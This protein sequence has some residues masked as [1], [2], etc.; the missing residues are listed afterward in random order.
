MPL[1]T[2]FVCKLS[3]LV[4]ALDSLTSRRA[5]YLLAAILAATVSLAA[6][7][8]T[9]AQLTLD[10]V[11]GSGGT[12]G[13]LIERKTGTTGAFAQIANTGA[14]VTT[15]ADTT[16]TAATTFCYRVRSANSGGT[17]GYSNEACGA[18][19]DSGTT[20]TIGKSGTGSGTVTSTPQGINCGTD[21]TE[22]FPAG[23]V[24]LMAAPAPGSIFGGW[25]GGGCTGTDAC[26][27]AGNVA[28]QVTATFAPTS[29]APTVTITSPASGST[30]S[31]SVTVVVAATAGSGTIAR[32]ELWIDGAL[33]ATATDAPYR[34]TGDS[35]GFSDGPHSLVARAYDTAGSVGTSAAVVLTNKNGRQP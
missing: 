13:F 18:A 1:V 9:G 20:L 32:V 24:T 28:L 7:A 21:C 25:S 4:R 22:S 17:S 33:V 10:W 26:V 16:V 3:G 31:G 5:R 6:G 8:A 12:A 30:V 2:G 23:T 35:A 14:G 34:F 29:A 15:Y 11:D 27:I 19:A